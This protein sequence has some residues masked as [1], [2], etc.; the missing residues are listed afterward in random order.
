LI[1][2]ITFYY[3]FGVPRYK[4]LLKLPNLFS[5]NLWIV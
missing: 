5:L 3:Y 4:Q 2:G 1:K